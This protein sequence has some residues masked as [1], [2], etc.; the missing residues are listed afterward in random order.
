MPSHRA[1][2]RLQF[3]RR[4]A[5]FSFYFY[6]FSMLARS[7]SALMHIRIPPLARWHFTDTRLSTYFS[8]SLNASFWIFKGK[9]GEKKGIEKHCIVFLSPEHQRVSLE[10]VSRETTLYKM[11]HLSSNAKSRKVRDANRFVAS[12]SLR[13]TFSCPSG[14]RARASFCVPHFT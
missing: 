8:T 6:V 13:A 14:L 10:R 3:E 7:K 5:L 11:L 1:Q 9:C 4:G 12:A 2:K